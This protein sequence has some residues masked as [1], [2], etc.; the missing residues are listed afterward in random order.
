MQY[1]IIFPRNSYK[2]R[3]NR[4]HVSLRSSQTLCSDYKGL[5]PT[6]TSLQLGK[7]LVTPIGR[8]NFTLLKTR[9]YECKHTYTQWLSYKEQEPP[10]RNTEGNIAKIEDKKGKI[11]LIKHKAVSQIYPNVHFSKCEVTRETK[12]I[13]PVTLRCCT[14]NQGIASTLGSYLVVVFCWLWK[15]LN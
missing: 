13:S 1:L 6:L 7:E 8:Q 11:R 4:T 9:T 14:W 12:D 2:G 3:D 5:N 15:H 10:C